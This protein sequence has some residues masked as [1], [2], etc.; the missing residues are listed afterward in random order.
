MVAALTSP[1]GSALS[2]LPGK[3]L[4]VE[5]ALRQVFAD[6]SHLTDERV[7]A[8]LAPVLRPGAFPAIRSLGASLR[9]H[10]NAVRDALPSIQAPTL[11]VWGREDRW[12]PLAH[13]DLFVAA[14]PGA[15]RA[16]IHGCG[17]VPQEEVPEELLRLVRGLLRA[18]EEPPSASGGRG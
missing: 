3:R 18:G 1:L 12:I 17:H 9:S 10:E 13:A 4:V 16:V 6:D 2:W 8:Y 7:S 11:V 5:M 14:I 15:K